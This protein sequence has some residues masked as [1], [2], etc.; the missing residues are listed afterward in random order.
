MT[1]EVIV[2]YGWS[3]WFKRTVPPLA[4]AFFLVAVQPWGGVIGVLMGFGFLLGWSW[5]LRRLC[6][7]WEQMNQ[8]ENAR[9]R[10]QLMSRQRHDSLNH[11]QVLMGY[12]SLNKPERISSY[13]E[14]IVN[15]WELERKVSQINDPVLACYLVTFIRDHAEWHWKMDLD[16]E[17]FPL[18]FKS[19]ERIFKIVKGVIDRLEIYGNLEQLYLGLSKKDENIIVELQPTWKS[20]QNPGYDLRLLRETISP[21]GELLD[22]SDSVEAIVIR[23]SS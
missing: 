16:E 8:K 21:Y 15:Q 22:E 19:S 18:P 6:R 13:L 5:W 7:G 1:G 23:L 9:S 4:V 2:S 12:L 14:K 17:A 11:I 3:F 10:L 20:V